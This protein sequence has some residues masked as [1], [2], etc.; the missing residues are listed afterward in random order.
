VHI[1]FDTDKDCN[2]LHDG[3]VPSTGRTSHSK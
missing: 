1:S 3:Q 2:V